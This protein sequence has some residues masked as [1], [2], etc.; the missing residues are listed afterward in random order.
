MGVVPERHHVA[1]PTDA[2]CARRAPIVRL[3]G[4]SNGG[5]PARHIGDELREQHDLTEPLPHSLLALLKQL[6]RIMREG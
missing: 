1:P 2:G 5:R 6:A 4:A 3:L